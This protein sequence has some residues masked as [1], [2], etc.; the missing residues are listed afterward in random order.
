MMK[1]IAFCFAVFGFAVVVF[2]C[3]SSRQSNNG[4]GVLG[5][6]GSA[7]NFCKSGDSSDRLRSGDGSCG[8]VYFD[9]DK[10][11]LTDDAKRILSDNAEFLRGKREKL[12]V[13]GNTDS[14]GTVEY[15]LA[16]GQ[17]RAT[18]VKDY[19]IGLGIAPDRIETV[20]YGEENIVDA[21]VSSKNR[22]AETKVLGK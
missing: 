18:S 16:L 22:R 4:S 1:R 6:G 20:S 5:S 19:Y 12:V 2:G 11:M 14:A 10:S 8:V 7:D 3:A 21:A 13:E 15:N 9:F 17:R